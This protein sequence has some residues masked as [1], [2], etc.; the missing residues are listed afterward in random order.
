[1]KYVME[2]NMK[3][4]LM[5]GAL[6][7]STGAVAGE[8]YY[9][10]GPDGP[11]ATPY[12]TADAAC[13]VVYATDLANGPP[14]SVDTVPL[15][16]TG[17]TVLLSS[18]PK[19]LVYACDT[20]WQSADGKTSIGIGHVIYRNG[21]NCQSNEVYNPL[22]GYCEAPD[23]EQKRKEQGDPTSPA[24]VGF[25][26]CGDPVNPASGNVFESETDY[27][28]QD[29]ELRFARSYNS[30]DAAG[31]VTTFNT[32]LYADNSVSPRGDVVLF[33]DG[34]SALFIARNGVL[35]ADGG[36]L[37]S[38]VQ[39]QSGWL[40]T[41]QFNE[42]MTFD[43]QGRLIR[44][45]KADGRATTIAYGTSSFDT[46]MT[47]TDSLGHQ[48]IYTTR[49]G[50]PL[51]LIAG[52]LTINYTV[53]ESFRLTVVTKSWPGHSTSRRYVYEDATNPKHLTGIIDERGVR[54]STWTYDADG[55]AL[56]ATAANGTG[57]FTFGYNSD[58]STTVTNPLGHPVDYQFAVVQGAKRITAIKGEPVVGCPASNSTFAYTS[59]AQ[60]S[61]RTDAVGHVTTFAYDASGR[62]I[63]RTEAKGTASERT[64]TTT[65]DGASFRAKTVTTPDRVTTY[66]YDPQGRLITTQTHSIK[67]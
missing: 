9:T 64:T 40:Y 62:E 7:F 31:W 61:S 60:L 13:R 54:V 41:S 53:D 5:L 59:G 46:V 12:P 48:M 44:W 67:E 52:N 32:H 25:V 56:S 39:T 26:T 21:D 22:S 4:F 49:N 45:Q 34:R 15:G 58:G 16:Y 17:P 33:E 37:G 66:D 57:R 14:N 10:I 18:P 50:W 8:Y 19:I 43:T 24:N 36:E 6:V 2:W 55:R 27:A 51:S 23:K 35:V 1:M 38:L 20:H 65:W 28:D 63:S 11:N 3:L 42:Q 29:G 47:I 30:T